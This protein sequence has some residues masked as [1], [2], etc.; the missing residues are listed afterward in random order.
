VSW[1]G[2]GSAG[3][4]E[5]AEHARRD[6]LARWYRALALWVARSAGSAPTVSF[7]GRLTL[8]D[9]GV[10]WVP[11][12][13][14]RRQGLAARRWPGNELDSSYVEWMRN[15]TP[16]GY[17]HV[18]VRGGSEAVFRVFQPNRLDKVVSSSRY[19]LTR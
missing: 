10:T 15:L 4:A 1:S 3:I 17:L 9:E 6:A 14:V 13:L 7:A 16:L 5:L 8:G 12:G 18:R 2:K 19:S 11:S